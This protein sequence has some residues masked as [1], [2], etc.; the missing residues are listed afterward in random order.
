MALDYDSTFSLDP[1][2]W[3]EALSLL[4][5]KTG[6]SIIGVTMRYEGETADIDSRY[7]DI[8]DRIFF[9]SRQAKI[10]FLR[11]RGIEVDVWIEDSPHWLFQNSA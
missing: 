6:W 7:G 4:K 1:A 3:F 11:E 10:A 5:A 9:T 2:A 8:C